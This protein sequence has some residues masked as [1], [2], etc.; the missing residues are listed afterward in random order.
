MT[1]LAPPVSQSK[2]I[3]K[4]K[5]LQAGIK[6]QQKVVEDFRE[7]VNE[8]MAGESNE[9]DEYGCH[10]QSFKSETMTEVSL[11]SDQLQFVNHELDEL[12]HIHNYEHE[13]H[14]MAEYGTVVKTDKEMFFISVGVERFYVDDLPV[15][16]LA[17]QSP[18]YKVMKGKKVGDSFTYN[19]TTHRIEEIF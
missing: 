17:V 7:R 15:F 9:K 16:G 4:A 2:N 18:V 6:Q 10:Q 19:G 5:V 13:C 8:I 12:R 11:L 3:F 14:P 1:S